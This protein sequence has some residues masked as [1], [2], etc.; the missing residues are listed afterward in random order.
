MRKKQQDRGG[1]REGDAGTGNFK[2]S[3]GRGRG[4]IELRSHKLC[5]VAKPKSFQGIL[6]VAWGVGDHAPGFL[7]LKLGCMWA[8]PGGLQQVP[9]AWVLPP[10]ILL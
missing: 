4:R 5:S 8:S 1:N 6:M 10:E 3:R 7:V 9:R 2:S